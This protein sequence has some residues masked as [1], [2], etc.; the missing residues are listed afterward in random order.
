MTS[1]SAMMGRYV[2]AGTGG[3]PERLMVLYVTSVGT[4]GST[5]LQ[6]ALL[7][8]SHTVQWALS[9]WSSWFIS[10][11]YPSGAFAHQIYV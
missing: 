9:I 10:K 8:D 5:A 6:L 11:L 1:G 7:T 3:S 2:C 4:S